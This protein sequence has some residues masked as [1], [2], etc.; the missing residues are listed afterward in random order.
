MRFIA[1]A[2]IIGALLCAAPA[3]AQIGTQ[4]P[5]SKAK[6]NDPGTVPLPIR[7]HVIVWGSGGLDLDVIGNVTTGAIGTIRGTQML[8]DTTAFPDVYV[9]TPRRYSVG[10]GLG[11]FDQTELFVRYSE[12]NN[13]AST[14][15][16]GRFG[17]NDNLFA[18][19]F[20]NY[21]ERTIEGGLRHYMGASLHFRE[22]FALNGGLKTVQPISLN[23]QAPG[24]AVPARL[25]NLSKVPTLGLD[26]GVQIEFRHIGLFLEAGARYQKRLVREDGDLTN[27]GLEDLNNS[28]IR[29]FMPVQ[30][31]LY[32]RF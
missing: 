11:V 19:A 7:W 21:R 27:Y 25:Y 5:S 22:Y 2:A 15:L 28:G 24:G 14:V 26:F 32:F 13:P 9:K 6:L 17:S 20:D 30:T 10:L 8:V 12:T 29:L 3:S 31:G 18:V 4:E 16:I 23:L 1:T